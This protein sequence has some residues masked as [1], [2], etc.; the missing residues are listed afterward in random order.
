MFFFNSMLDVNGVLLHNVATPL[1]QVSGASV[2]IQN[3]LRGNPR[4][5]NPAVGDYHLGSASAARDAGIPTGHP[6][7]STAR[8]ARWGSGMT[9][10]RTSTP[11]PR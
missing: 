10:A 3:A 9:W 5:A 2:S 7:T 8:S 1:S 6:T 4:F 11:M